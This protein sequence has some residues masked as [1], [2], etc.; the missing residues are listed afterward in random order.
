M[1]KLAA[2]LIADSLLGTVLFA[3]HL[4]ENISQF[5]ALFLSALTLTG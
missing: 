4:I 3:H 1:N 2:L 5:F